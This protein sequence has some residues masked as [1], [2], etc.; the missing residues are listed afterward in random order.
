MKSHVSV[1]FDGVMVEVMI[2]RTDLTKSIVNH[3]VHATRSISNA[4]MGG[5]FHPKAIVTVFL[6]VGMDLTRWDA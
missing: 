1:N 2:V 3:T 5:A 4:T 6:R